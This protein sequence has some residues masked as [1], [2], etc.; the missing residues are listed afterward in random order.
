M[1][2]PAK[3]IVARTDPDDIVNILYRLRLK[4]Q[5]A[6]TP[7]LSIVV[8]NA[9]VQYPSSPSAAPVYDPNKILI[10]DE[11]GN[12]ATDDTLSWD[13]ATSFVLGSLIST[14]TVSGT[15]STGTQI[16]GLTIGEWYAVE[17]ANGPFHMGGGSPFN[18]DY[19]DFELSLD[20]VTFSGMIGY[21]NT[22]AL[23]HLDLPTFAAYAEA[24]DTHNA[25]VY[26]KAIS[27]SVWFRAIDGVWTDN[28]GSLDYKLSNATAP[29][30]ITLDGVEYTA[31][32][33]PSV[34]HDATAKTT[35]A[36][37]DEFGIWD[38]VTGLFLKITWANIKAVLDTLYAA[39]SHTHSYAPNAF[40]TI[41]V[42]GQSDVVA[43]SITDTLTLVAGTNITITTDPTTDTI[44]ITAA[45]SGGSGA[46]QVTR[47][48]RWASGG[49]TTYDLPDFAEYLIDASDNGS[50]VDPL[51]Y[52][53]SSDGSQLVFDSA[54]T[55]GHIVTSKFIVAQI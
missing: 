4:F 6:Q 8:Q 21:N 14:A 40:S 47:L 20:G 36:N 1:S 2:T 17:G 37:A 43:D 38:S 24:V 28:S 3:E 33:M 11:L 41:A 31:Y 32:Q 52:S 35:L 39:I 54:I 44:T 48:A 5:R 50:E 55:A 19:Y 7:P 9:P 12:I 42:S 29:G 46:G 26:F 45:S 18:G 51:T 53:L 22:D 15:S 23:M 13:P 10:T 16:T 34:I 49:G 25:R 27:T 30:S